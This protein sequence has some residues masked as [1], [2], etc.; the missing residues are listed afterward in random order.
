[1]KCSLSIPLCLGFAASPFIF[2]SGFLMIRKWL[3]SVYLPQFSN[4]FQFC[5]KTYRWIQDWWS[6]IDTSFRWCMALFPN[7]QEG[8]LLYFW[9]ERKCWTFWQ[10]LHPGRL[11]FILLCS[12]LYFKSVFHH[13]KSIQR[14][15]VS[16]NIADLRQ[17]LVENVLNI[18]GL[19]VILGVNNLALIYIL[20]YIYQTP[21]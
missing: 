19:A 14:K 6:C 16:H 17:S 9:G 18:Y 7:L 20:G 11:C 3:L 4:F 12:L 10:L 15:P 8:L 5:M 2:L 1:M 21:R 13:T